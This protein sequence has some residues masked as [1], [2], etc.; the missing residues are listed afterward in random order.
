M[1][2]KNEPRNEIVS[3]LHNPYTIWHI[4]VLAVLR[5]GM[6]FE[7][8]LLG[9]RPTGPAKLP[10]PWCIEWRF[11]EAGKPGSGNQYADRYP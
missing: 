1:T 5:G 11:P 7:M 9:V 3:T 10:D 6:C 8:T 4:K 2:S